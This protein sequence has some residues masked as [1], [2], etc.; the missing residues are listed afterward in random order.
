MPKSLEESETC[1][2]CLHRNPRHDKIVLLGIL[3]NV[4]ANR[5]VACTG[6]RGNLPGIR[7]TPKSG[8]GNPR[9]LVELGL[10]CFLG[11]LTHV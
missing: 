11:I 5:G 10:N 4:S 1:Q 8:W 2:N 3:V 9:K 7:N 6:I